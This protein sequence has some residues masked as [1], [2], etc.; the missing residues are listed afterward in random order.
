MLNAVFAIIDKPLIYWYDLTVNL[1]GR[2]E[3]AKAKSYQE[4]FYCRTSND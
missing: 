2:R 4:V 1:L 3:N